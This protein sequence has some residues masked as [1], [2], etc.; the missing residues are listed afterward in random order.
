[1]EFLNINSFPHYFSSLKI[2]EKVFLILF[3]LNFLFLL[4]FGREYSKLQLT[5]TFYVQD[6]FYGLITLSSFFFKSSLRLK[7]I[8][9][10]IVISLLYLVFSLINYTPEVPLALYFRQYM[11]FGYMAGTYFIVKAIFNFKNGTVMLFHSIVFI[12]F[13]SILTQFFYS[14]YYFISNNELPFFERNY[15]SPL[16]VLGVIATGVFILNRYEGIKR[17]LLYLLVIIVSFT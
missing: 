17:Q 9:V 3:L 11:I 13:L 1:M 15:F 8:E 2:G 5:D 14:C 12:A 7:S 10:L 16:V 6:T 4:F